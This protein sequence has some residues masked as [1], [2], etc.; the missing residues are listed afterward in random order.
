LTLSMPRR[1][2]AARGSRFVGTPCFY[3]AAKKLTIT[4]YIETHP[5]RRL[6]MAAFVACHHLLWVS[7]SKR[8]AGVVHEQAFGQALF[9]AI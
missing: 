2:G 4:F 7:Q 8:A 6:T 3:G 5:K 9:R 1:F